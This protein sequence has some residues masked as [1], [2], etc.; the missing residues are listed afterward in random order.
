MSITSAIVFYM[1]CWAVTF[2]LINPLWQ[3]SQQET[4][5]IVPGTPASA[6]VDAMIGRKALWTTVWASCVF[7]LLFWII[8]YQ[9]VTLDDIS[10][11]RLP[12][13]R[14]PTD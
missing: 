14:L 1:V 10:W 7:A 9:V 11:T 8:E 12:S 5:E 4:G 3:R 2:M 6:P 13:E